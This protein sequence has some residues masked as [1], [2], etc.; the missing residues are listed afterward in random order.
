MNSFKILFCVFP[1]F[2]T[3]IGL[4]IESIYFILGPSIGSSEPGASSLARQASEH[5]KSVTFDDGVKPGV[6]TTASAAAAIAATNIMS[7]N[8]IRTNETDTDQVSLFRP[9]LI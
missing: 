1:F 4:L 3:Y 7:S 8:K 5:K 9:G 6:E 2:Y